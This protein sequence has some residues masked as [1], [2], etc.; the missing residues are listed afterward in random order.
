MTLG[1]FFS[2]KDIKKPEK[3]EN[4]FPLNN[5]LSSFFDD[6]QDIYFDPRYH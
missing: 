3:E 6:I 1:I 4:F 5:E 2:Q